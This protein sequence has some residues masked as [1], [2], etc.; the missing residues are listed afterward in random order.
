MAM[1]IS[2]K[3]QSDTCELAA[4]LPGRVCAARWRGIGHFHI[5]CGR[6]G[7]GGGAVAF[8]Q[9][10]CL[11]LCIGLGALLTQEDFV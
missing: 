11:R 10:L 2:N 9:R 8:A 5:G 6:G 3:A 4:V 7:S 1:S